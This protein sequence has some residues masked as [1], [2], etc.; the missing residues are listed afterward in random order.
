MCF[1]PVSS[2]VKLQVNLPQQFPFSYLRNSMAAPSSVLAWRI[3]GTEKP[4]GL[5]SM[6][7][8]R[9][10][11]D[12]SDL[13]PPAAAA[14][15]IFYLIPIILFP[16]F[17]SS[18]NPKVAGPEVWSFDRHMQEQKISKRERERECVCVC[19]CVCVFW[20]KYMPCPESLNLDIHGGSDTTR[21]SC[22]VLWMLG[23]DQ[24][25]DWII[26]WLS[27]EDFGVYLQ[28][29][30]V[31]SHSISATNLPILSS[32]P[33]T[34][35]LQWLLHSALSSQRYPQVCCYC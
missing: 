8:H 14:V 7:S 23:R 1:I 33:K 35:L 24:V 15:S 25:I 34:P 32:L 10:E 30:S 9:V 4:G 20:L 12:W 31:F 2:E 28:L 19:V 16:K 17:L 22:V 11:H 26:L 18:L 6:G 13:A 21:G 3:P 29:T 5:L 27:V